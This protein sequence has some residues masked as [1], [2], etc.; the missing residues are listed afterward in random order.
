MDKIWHNETYSWIH[1]LVLKY[2]KIK[3]DQPLIA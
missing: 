2:A 1:I 3:Q